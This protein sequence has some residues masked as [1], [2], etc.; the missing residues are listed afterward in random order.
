MS[1]E[2]IKISLNGF[3]DPLDSSL[4]ATFG[5]IDFITEN[6]PM[7]RHEIIMRNMWTPNE[8]KGDERFL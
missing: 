7:P 3:Y 8:L 6:D 2:P 5:E 1:V 4:L